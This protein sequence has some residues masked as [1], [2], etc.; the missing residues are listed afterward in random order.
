MTRIWWILIQALR[1][2][3]NLHFDWS[4]L[5]KVYKVWSKKVQRSYISWHWIVT[6]SLKKKW[7]VVWKM[8]WE[9]WQIF[10]RT[11]ENIKIVTFM[12]SFC[13]KVEKNYRAK[14]ELKIYREV[15][16]NDTEEWW[17]IYRGI[18]LSF[19]NRHKEFDKFWVKNS[20]V[21]KIYTLTLFRMSI[22]GVV[23]RLGSKSSPS[24][25]S[26]AHILQWWNLAY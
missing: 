21:S 4:L 17:K 9:I 22:F 23:H 7:L 13:P 20:N 8:T 3:T 10:I 19:Q 1:S 14:N 18:D 25:K 5:C 24:L 15:M 26:V 6:Q 12:G 11:L 16:C 2:L